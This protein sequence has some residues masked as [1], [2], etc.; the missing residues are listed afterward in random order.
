MLRWCFPL[1][2]FSDREGADQNQFKPGD[3]CEGSYTQRPDSS[4][5]SC[6]GQLSGAVDWFLS[7]NTEVK[8]EMR[9]VAGS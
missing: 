7:Q 4:H 3:R 9:E 6:Y 8:I 2:W 1:A 5:L